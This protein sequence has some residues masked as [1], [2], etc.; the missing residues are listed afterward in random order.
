MKEKISP[1]AHFIRQLRLTGIHCEVLTRMLEGD[2]LKLYRSGS[3]MLHTAE[4]LKRTSEKLKPATLDSLTRKGMIVLDREKSGEDGD[5][6]VLTE[7]GE[8]A[9]RILRRGDLPLW[10]RKN[11]SRVG[12]RGRVHL[13]QASQ[14]HWRTCPYGKTP[15]LRHR[16]YN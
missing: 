15:R 7:D 10:I 14:A 16:R 5:V 3:L 13:A 1:P 6:F 9:A 2:D 8:T 11:N 12:D 4:P